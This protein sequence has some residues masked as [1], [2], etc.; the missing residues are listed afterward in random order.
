MFNYYQMKQL[1]EK[2]V[3]PVVTLLGF[4]NLYWGTGERSLI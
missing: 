1:L 2:T 3:Y 4:D